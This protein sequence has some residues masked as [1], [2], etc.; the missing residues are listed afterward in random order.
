MTATGNATETR[1]LVVAVTG[2]NATDSPA[3][4]VPVIRAV[5]EGAGDRPVRIVGLAYEPLDPGLYM[6]GICDSGYLMPFPSQGGD[7]VMARLAAIHAEERID[8]LLPTLD[9]ELPIFTRLEAELR[10][11][12]IRSYLPTPDQ[13]KLRSKARFNALRETCGIRVPDGRVVTDLASLHALPRELPYPFFV[14]GQFYE[15]Y[16]ARTPFEAEGFFH[17]LAAKWGLPVVVQEQ[18]PGEEYD[19]VA[20]G[21]G[22]GG[23]IGAVPMRKMQLTDKGKAWGGITI[24]S[25]ELEEFTRDTMARLKWRGPCELEVMHSSR[26]GRHYLLEVNPRFPAWVYL[27]AGAGQNLPWAVVRLAL[28]EDVGE[29]PP[30]R[31][32]VMFL[33]HSFDQICDLEDYAAISTLG[34][35]RRGGAA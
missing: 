4:G 30:Y 3:P 9:A 11:M 5:R 12:G 21:D 23:L 17:K 35:F 6:P 16:L 1:P 27:S 19:V 14:K 15:A 34:G 20:V 22:E 31:V 32:G 28:G 8:V 33:R 10:G 2:L 26:D 18:I 29:L 24:A 7:A 25:P 13:L